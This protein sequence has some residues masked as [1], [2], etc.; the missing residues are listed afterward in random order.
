[1]VYVVMG[2]DYP[3]CCFS[4]QKAADAYCEARRKADRT[5][6]PDYAC[7]IYWRTYAFTVRDN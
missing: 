5:T 2:N 6:A 3:D 7:R 4:S 1:M